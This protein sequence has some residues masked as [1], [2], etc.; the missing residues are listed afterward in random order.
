VACE[1]LCGEY[2][3]PKYIIFAERYLEVLVSS[4]AYVV[5]S[6]YLELHWVCVISLTSEHGHRVVKDITSTLH[7]LVHPTGSMALFVNWDRESLSTTIIHSI[8]K[9]YIEFVR[10]V[11]E[12]M[13]A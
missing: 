12:M 7:A 2:V 11:R 3:G 10:M 8:D 6:V 1:K 4:H 13:G 5:S 9:C